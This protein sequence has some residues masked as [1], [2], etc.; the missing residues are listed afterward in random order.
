[1][2][3]ITLR[4]AKVTNLNF[5]PERAG[6]DL[7][8]RVDLSLEFLLQ[9]DEIEELLSTVSN[10]LK[11]LWHSSGNP[12]LRDAD[13]IP[14][15]CKASGKAQLGSEADGTDAVLYFQPSTLK[16][17][18]VR[19]VLGFNLEVTC[20]VRVDP[21]GHLEELG[22]IRIAEES[23]FAFLGEAEPAPTKERGVKADDDQEEMDV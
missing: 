10:P 19:P 13:W 9:R 5:Q 12:Q 22:D 11:V 2:V 4:T 7:L 6:D 8:E 14:L 16:K 17:I 3:N 18:K 23:A 15:T 1:M 20:Q 21:T